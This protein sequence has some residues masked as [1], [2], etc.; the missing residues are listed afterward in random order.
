MSAKRFWTIRLL[1]AL[2]LVVLFAGAAQAGWQDRL[3]RVLSSGDPSETA[4]WAAEKAGANL[5]RDAYGF[6]GPSAD[7]GHQ[8]EGIGTPGIAGQ[9][10]ATPSIKI[11]EICTLEAC[12]SATS[13]V[14]EFAT[15]GLASLEAKTEE[16]KFTETCA[17]LICV[18][19]FSIPAQHLASTPAT[20]LGKLSQSVYVPAIC[21]A[22]AGA[23]LGEQNLATQTIA[24]TPEIAPMQITEA[25][26][27][28]V[29]VSGLEAVVDSNLGESWALGP[30]RMNVPVPVVGMVPVTLCP[31]S[32]LLPALAEAQLGAFVNV[33][34]MTHAATF[35]TSVPLNFTL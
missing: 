32:C 26:G 33:S 8:L 25:I 30:I 7:A 15:P 14:I 11:G 27:F 29:S 10:V 4:S 21:S 13:V 28:A 1:A 35:Q 9:S 2:S 34:L 12:H 31:N 16:I 23:C 6:S 24:L 18:G 5:V 20:E 3:E 17:E 22:G 19:A